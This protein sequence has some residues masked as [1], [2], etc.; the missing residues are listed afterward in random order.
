MT[1]GSMYLLDPLGLAMEDKISQMIKITMK[2]NKVDFKQE[3]TR[4]DRQKK[5]L[6][7]TLLIN[8]GII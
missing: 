1:I 5:L 6:C 2:S 7:F 3:F 4:K 8:I